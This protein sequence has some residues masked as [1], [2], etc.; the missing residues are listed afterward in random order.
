MHV[1]QVRLI[2]NNVIHKRFVCTRARVHQNYLLLQV[3][4]SPFL[5]NLPTDS[6]V[7]LTGDALSCVHVETVG[8]YV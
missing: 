4:I 2:R 6:V 5:L 3:V 1:N 8:I 7:L